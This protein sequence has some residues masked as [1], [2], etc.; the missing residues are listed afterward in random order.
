MENILVCV[1]HPNHAERLIQRG[2][3]L[4]EAFGGSCL[5][6]SVHKNHMDDD[7]DFNQ[8]QTK[9]MFQTLAEK[10]DVK[11]L[12]KCSEG[13]KVSIVIADT[14]KEENITQIVIG[15]AVQSKLE[16]VMK[17]SIINE[18]F[19][20]LEGVDVH[21]VEV[22]REVHNQSEFCD[23]GINSQIVKKDSEYYLVF[24]D[25]QEEGLDGIFFR[26]L[27]T[28]FSNG[29]FVIQKENEH[30][31]V[32]VRNGVVQLSDLDQS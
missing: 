23:R 12:S 9:L 29:F 1:S 22:N 28:N 27:S 26:E 7:L 20:Q 2:R 14:A 3:L 19:Q 15:Q 11:M 25:T 13:K 18:L 5:V 4:A 10:Y 8:L 30:Q 21:V 24:D 32:R 6:L 31:V 16:L 17:Q